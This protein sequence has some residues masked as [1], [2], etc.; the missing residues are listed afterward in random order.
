[1]VTVSPTARTR[2]LSAGN[3]VAKIAIVIM[4]LFNAAF[5]VPGIYYGLTLGH[6]QPIIIGVGSSLVFWLLV[7]G[8][9]KLAKARLYRRFGPDAEPTHH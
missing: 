5:L 3:L 1:M 2:L 9:A 8:A 4:I 7:W 6:H